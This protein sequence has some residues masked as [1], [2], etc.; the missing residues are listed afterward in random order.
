MLDEGMLRRVLFKQLGLRDGVGSFSSS[1]ISERPIDE[2]GLRANGLAG[3]ND[4]FGW[5][6]KQIAAFIR[7][8]PEM[9]FTNND[10]EKGFE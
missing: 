4:V 5:S 8:N 3:L 1:P 9:V 2:D 7:E 6:F 10:K